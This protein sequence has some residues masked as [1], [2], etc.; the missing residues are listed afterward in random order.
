MR[1]ASGLRVAS[2]LPLSSTSFRV[3][4]HHPFD[5]PCFKFQHIPRD[6]T[7]RSFVSSLDRAEKTHKCPFQTCELG[8]TNS[9][10]FYRYE[11][12]SSIIVNE[13]NH[14]CFFGGAVIQNPI[15]EVSPHFRAHMEGYDYVEIYV[16]LPTKKELLP[17]FR[18]V[19]RPDL[20]SSTAD[21]AKR[22]THDGYPLIL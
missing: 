22:S 20:R 12:H 16:P 21:L 14:L 10:P 18:N 9:K 8:G 6:A 17:E 1:C 4:W 7:R 19:L 5:A 13:S 15:A 2:R 11:Y 3:L